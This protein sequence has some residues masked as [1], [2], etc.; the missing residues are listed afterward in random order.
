[1]G[2]TRL[3]LLPRPKEGDRFIWREKEDE[4]RVKLHVQCQLDRM[5]AWDS[6][7]ENGG[8]G[9]RACKNTSNL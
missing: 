3:V 8:K 7:Q 1:M 6:R 2:L 5:K 4:K 9:M